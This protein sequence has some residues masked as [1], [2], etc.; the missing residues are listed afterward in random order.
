MSKI[1][2][3]LGYRNKCNTV[4]IKVIDEARVMVKEGGNLAQPLKASGRFPP[5]VTHMIAVG[6]RSGALEE[7]LNVVA[8]AYE[9]QVDARIQTLTTLLEPVMIVGLSGKLRKETSRSFT[10]SSTMAKS[11]DMPIRKLSKVPRPNQ[12]IGIT[13]EDFN[14]RITF[15]MV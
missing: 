7:M 13:I 11:S 5:M 10:P 2:Y 15:I 6:E 1:Q 12:C 3:F 8:D 9:S 14:R 4:L